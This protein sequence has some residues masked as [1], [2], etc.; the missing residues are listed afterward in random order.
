MLLADVLAGN[1][2]TWL[3]QHRF[4]WPPVIVWDYIRW[5]GALAS[6]VV[7]GLCVRMARQFTADRRKANNRAQKAR[8]IALALFATNTALL[9]INYIG[10]APTYRIPVSLA[11]QVFAIYG[12]LLWNPAV[13]DKAARQQQGGRRSTRDRRRNSD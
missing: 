9:N 6:G 10:V 8:Y 1:N 7:V 11:A 13:R 5:A 2:G 3:D 12:L 4:S